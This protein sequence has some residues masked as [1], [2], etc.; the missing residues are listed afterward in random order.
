VTILASV[1]H[2]EWCPAGTLRLNLMTGRYTVTAPP[3]WRECIRPVW[4]SLVRAGVIGTGVLAGI[5]L[6]YARTR[7]EGLE[8]PDCR[9]NGQ[10]PRLV[11]SNGGPRSLSLVARGMTTRP[12][13]NEGCWS[14]AASRLHR[15][16]D[17]RFGPAGQPSPRA[18]RS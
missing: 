6:A 18:S 15:L 5:R 9:N 1:G 3:R 10:P 16:L 7:S 8:A 13:R 4:P 2:S 14:D 17:D 12:P 11:I